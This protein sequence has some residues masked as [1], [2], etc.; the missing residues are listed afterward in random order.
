MEEEKKK[1]RR[2]G[3]LGEGQYTATNIADLAGV[4]VSLIKIKLYELRRLRG[5]E[6]HDVDL[7]GLIA[8]CHLKRRH[9]AINKQLRG[10]L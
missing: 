2:L 9:S 8:D 7:G 10:L 4:S 5:G 3:S 1:K 6:I